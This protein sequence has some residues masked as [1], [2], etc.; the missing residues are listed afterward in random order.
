MEPWFL[1]LRTND[2]Q[3]HPGY[4]IFSSLDNVYIKL[5]VHET[6][7]QVRL[8]AFALLTSRVGIKN[9]PK[10]TQKPTQKNPKTH[11]KKPLK[12]FFLGFF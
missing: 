5:F 6:G 1:D 11:L 12:M 7:L 10:K 4:M 8:L 9:P 2:C 3:V